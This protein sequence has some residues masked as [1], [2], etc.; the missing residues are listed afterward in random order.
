MEAQ[1]PPTKQGTQLTLGRA[2]QLARINIVH[3]P[4]RSAITGIGIMLGVAFLTYVL[5]W[6]IVN[7]SIMGE[8]VATDIYQVQQRWLVSLS[9]L[10]CAVGVM[11]TMLMSVVER[12]RE[13][14]TMKCLGA[15]DW[16]IFRLFVC[17]AAF[18]GLAGSVF[19]WVLAV[20]CV[21][22]MSLSSFGLEGVLSFPLTST[23]WALFL[24]IGVGTA[25]AIGSA[26]YPSHYASHMPPAAAMR[27]E[28]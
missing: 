11:N 4:G 18:M 8:E 7:R 23:F 1:R 19:G 16:F 2:I 22:I 10:T 3:R 28:F 24:S 17:E 14:G 13:I 12:Y 25:L 9:L 6:G 15:P 27:V 26:I 5:L 21:F 20:L